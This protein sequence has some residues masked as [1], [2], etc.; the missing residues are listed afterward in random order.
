MDFIKDFIEEKVATARLASSEQV[1]IYSGRSF[2]LSDLDDPGTILTNLTRDSF[3]HVE[4]YG[5][6]TELVITDQGHET[7]IVFLNGAVD[8]F[9]VQ[10]ADQS[11]LDMRDLDEH[12]H[13]AI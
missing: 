9:K 12:I 3:K 8:R 11:Y 6:T 1:Y 4:T 7:R 2:E 13:I 5:K 10:L